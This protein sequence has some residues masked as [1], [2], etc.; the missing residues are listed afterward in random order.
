MDP[1]YLFRKKEKLSQKQ[2]VKIPKGQEASKETKKII[3]QQQGELIKIQNTKICGLHRCLIDSTFVNLPLNK[4]LII[5]SH[6][7]EGIIKNL[8]SGRLT[9]VPS[10]K[11]KVT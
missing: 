1:E 5:P 6:I 9:K 4:F 8:L 7:F 11:H 3:P 10:L 2:R